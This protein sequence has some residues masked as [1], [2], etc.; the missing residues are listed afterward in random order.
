M[1]I[2]VESDYRTRFESCRG[3][4][5]DR[6]TAMDTRE[7]AVFA[8]SDSDSTLYLCPAHALFLWNALGAMLMMHEPPLLKRGSGPEVTEVGKEMIK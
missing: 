1:S 2:S 5:Y 7:I 3:C 6:H 4:K 8:L